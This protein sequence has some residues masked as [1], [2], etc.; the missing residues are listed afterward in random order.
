MKV[1]I[2]SLYYLFLILPFIFPTYLLTFSIIDNIVK[3]WKII[4]VLLALPSAIYR[5]DFSPM[6]LL[7]TLFYFVLI[8]S[9]II[10]NI[11]PI[12]WLISLSFLWIFDYMTKTYENRRIFFN[13][14]I[15]VFSLFV[16]INLLTM[17]FYRSGLYSTEVYDLNWF[18]GYKNVLIRKV[19]PYITIVLVASQGRKKF[20]YEKIG[21]VSSF[22]SIILSTSI[23][24]ILGL[25]SFVLMVLY[26]KTKKNIQMFK[27]SNVFIGYGI[28]DIIMLS[29]GFLSNFD[30]ILYTKLDKHASLTG[31]FNIWDR[32]FSLIKVSPIIGY[33]FVASE[34]YN[35][36][37]K[38]SHPHNLLLYYM[39]IGG[40]VGLLVFLFSLFEVDKAMKKNIN[41][42]TNKIFIASYFSYFITAFSESLVGAI[43]FIPFLL[44]I[45]NINK[46]EKIE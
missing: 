4:A 27:L 38:I 22:I 33:G 30:Y 26:L 8:V 29:T 11:F 13:V 19:L 42:L 40:I 12:D 7:L 9:S 37:F 1:K 45:Y 18:L 5:K 10:H 16:I 35:F 21:L 43:F 31:R 32:T 28:L 39:M 24:G 34:L 20:W 3:I 46:E 14:Y 25:I 2:K 41:N 6:L 15:K 36:S 44:L 23:N 17:F